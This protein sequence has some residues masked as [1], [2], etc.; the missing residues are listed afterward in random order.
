MVNKKTPMN[1]ISNYLRNIFYWLEG[2][3][4]V[5]LLVDWSIKMGNFHA[6]AYFKLYLFTKVRFFVNIIT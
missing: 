2:G 3:G 6:I 5:H 4:L 1:Q